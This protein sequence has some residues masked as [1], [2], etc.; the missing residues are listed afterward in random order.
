ML[1]LDS[2]SS[3][4]TEQCTSEGAGISTE[5]PCKNLSSTE[6]LNKGKHNQDVE[7]ESTHSWA[8]EIPKMIQL[9]QALWEARSRAQSAPWPGTVPLNIL[10]FFLLLSCLGHRLWDPTRLAA[11]I[12]TFTSLQAAEKSSERFGPWGQKIKE[13]KQKEDYVLKLD[14][15]AQILPK[16]AAWNKDLLKNISEFNCENWSELWFSEN[17]I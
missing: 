9:K 17:M 10:L 2:E 3:N 4:S 15:L 5:L 12:K 16:Y 8:P 6:P 13:H 7:N 11:L 14:N 1:L